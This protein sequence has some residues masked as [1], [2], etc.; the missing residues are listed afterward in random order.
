MNQ[1]L[2]LPSCGEQL[3]VEELIPESAVERLGKAVLPRGSCLDVG[4]AGGAGGL[5]PAP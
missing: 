1:D 4:R 3:S 2:R 5:A